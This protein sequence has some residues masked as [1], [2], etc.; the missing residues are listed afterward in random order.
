MKIALLLSL[1][2]VESFATADTLHISASSDLRVL[3]DTDDEVELQLAAASLWQGGAEE[4]VL[5]SSRLAP[6]FNCV[7]ALVEQRTGGLEGTKFA[8]ELLEGITLQGG[9][10]TAALRQ[11]CKS[12]RHDH[13]PVQVDRNE[14]ARYVS[15]L[16][17]YGDRVRTLLYRFIK[18][19]TTCYSISGRLS[20]G[21]IAAFGGDIALEYCRANNGRHWLQTALEA[22]VGYGIGVL[23]LWRAGNYR[24]RMNHLGGPFTYTKTRHRDWAL[25]FGLSKAEFGEDYAHRQRGIIIAIPARRNKRVSAGLGAAYLRTWGKRIGLKFLPL[26][27]RD[28]HL[29]AEYAAL[30]RRDLLREQASIAAV[31]HTGEKAI[32]QIEPASDN[33]KVK[34]RLCS[35]DTSV[36]EDLLGG[37]YFPLDLIES[38][39]ARLHAAQTTLQK[40]AKQQ[41]TYMVGAAIVATAASAPVTLKNAAGKFSRTAK[42]LPSSWDGFDFNAYRVNK[43]RAKKAWQPLQEFLQKIF[44]SRP[45]R[46]L[47]ER[48]SKTV[49]AWNGLFVKLGRERIIS[50]T[51]RT[52]IPAIVIVSSGVTVLLTSIKL[53]KQELTLT[54]IAEIKTQQEEI[55]TLLQNPYQEV[56]V[57]DRTLLL[58][59]LRFL[60]SQP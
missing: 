27:T 5:D 38:N 22:E 32:L 42:I 52:G 54:K 56:L 15:R 18:P 21:L 12:F 10:D 9:E 6:V 34:F 20:A 28:E 1:L 46:M 49:E 25:G 55:F 23:S 58:Q 8:A 7:R 44:D 35:P 3:F 24:Y 53:A 39:L 4:Q 51:L 2:A 47:G 59:S 19:T 48:A 40:E 57:H 45:A 43:G 50:K 36:C 16:R 26:G 41:R 31:L 17:Q 11:Q 60:V 30:S 29:L 33:A 13:R 37:R 14:Q